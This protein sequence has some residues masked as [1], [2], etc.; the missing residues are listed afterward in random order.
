MATVRDQIPV[1]DLVQH[2]LD[3]LTAAE[4]SA[5]VTIVRREVNLDERALF[6]TV[7]L[8]EPDKSTVRS[9]RDGT[10]IHR[11]AFVAVLDRN[12]GKTYEGIVSLTEDRL[13]SWQHKPGI[14]PRMMADEMEE[15]SRLIKSHP[16]YIA[17]LKKRGIEDLDKVLVGWFPQGRFGA[18]EEK[19][20]RITRA[21]SQYVDAPGD[22][23]HVRPIEGLA[24]VIDLDSMEVLRSRISGFDP[25]PPKPGTT[26]RSSKRSYATHRPGSISPNRTARASRSTGILSPGRTGLSGRFH[27]P[28]RHGAAHHQ[29]SGWRSGASHHLPGFARRAG[30]PLRGDR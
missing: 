28:R 3:P 9:Y 25:F 27:A 7:M 26:G 12:A 19:G 1:E 11:E 24:P 21:H 10:D 17:A 8:R 23:P 6:E 29:L 5:T 4:L 16:D 14:Q 18:E 13:T 2:P 15:L 20:R 22:N 30:G